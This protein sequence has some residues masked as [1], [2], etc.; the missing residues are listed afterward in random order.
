VPRLPGDYGPGS[1]STGYVPTAWY[2]HRLGLIDDHGRETACGADM[3]AALDHYCAELVAVDAEHPRYCALYRYAVPD[4]TRRRDEERGPEWSWQAV[5]RPSLSPQGKP[6][7][8][9]K[10]GNRFVYANFWRA[11]LHLAGRDLSHDAFVMPDLVAKDLARGE[12]QAV[13]L[14][15]LGPSIPTARLA[16][17][18]A[19]RF[20]MPDGCRPGCAA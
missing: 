3:R 4:G 18:G 15:Y 11:R 16:N 19:L 5:R 9:A 2:Q 17:P 20:P 14:L 1:C 13:A 10:L 8:G 6:L 7:S 12:H